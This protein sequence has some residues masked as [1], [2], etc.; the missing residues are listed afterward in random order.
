MRRARDRCPRRRRARRC[1]SNATRYEYTEYARPRFSR[2]SWNRRDDIPPPSAWFT[3]DE[4]VAVRVVAG[5]RAH[6]ERRRAPARSARRSPR[7]GSGG[8]KPTGSIARRAG[9]RRRRR[10]RRR[11]ARR[12]ASCSRLP[13]AATTTLLRVGSARGGTAAIVVARIAAMIV[14]GCRAPSA[15]AGAPGTAPRRR[16]RGR[17]R[18][19]CRRA[20]GSLRGSPGARS[21]PRRAGTPA[22]TTTSERMSSASSSWSSGTRT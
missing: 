21:R 11:P 6:A 7:D 19:A 9:R 17:G 1:S 13:A 22:T 16:A 20:S 14:V 18:R 3:T 12:P 5:Q 10:A 15:R 4:R 2:T 8:A